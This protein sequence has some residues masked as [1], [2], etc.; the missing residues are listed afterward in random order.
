[1]SPI[2]KQITIFNGC[3]IQNGKVLL[4]KRSEPECPQAHLK[5]ELPG[6]KVDF[7]ETP[8]KALEREFF[9]ETG[10]R[11]KA[12]E[13]LDIAQSSLWEYEW[14]IQQ[15]LVLGFVCKL[16]NKK[17]KK[18]S[19]HHVEEIEWVDLERVKN[20]PTLPGTLESIAEALKHL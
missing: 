1:M 16:I 8:R 11:V 12:L 13:L 2:K 9:E 18:I 14:G 5:W 3:L 17:Q 4:V 7:G 15:V 19:D 6:G 10:Y 20:L